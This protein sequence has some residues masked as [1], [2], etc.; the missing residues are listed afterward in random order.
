MKLY[1]VYITN[2][3]MITPEEPMYFLKH[4]DAYPNWGREA[5]QDEYEADYDALCEEYGDKLILDPVIKA[6]N[7]YYTLKI[8]EI[9]VKDS[10]PLCDELLKRA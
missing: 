1:A 3:M 9:E 8:R 5:H 4:N 7:P 6:I 2:T 10:T